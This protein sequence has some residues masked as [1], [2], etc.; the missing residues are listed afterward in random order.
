VLGGVLKRGNHKFAGL[1]VRRHLK[2]ETERHS[3]QV[4]ARYQDTPMS[5]IQIKKTKKP[6]NPMSN[7][8]LLPNLFYKGGI[9]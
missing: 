4:F 7:E 6:Q 8:I 1:H 9:M 3:Y 2:V 5:P